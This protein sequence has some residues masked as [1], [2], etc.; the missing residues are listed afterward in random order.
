MQDLGYHQDDKICALATGWGQSALGVI[1]VSGEASLSAL[2]TVFSR[3]RALR[4]ASGNSLVYGYIL[5]A[6]GG[7]PVDQVLVAVFRGGRSYTGQE[8]AE[9]TCHGGIPAVQG[10]LE[11]LRGAGFRDAAPGEFTLRAFVSGKI[12]LT[13]AEAVHEIVT[14]KTSRAHDLALHRLSGSVEARVN[15]VKTRLVKMMSALELQ[16]DYPEDEVGD[17]ILPAPE[18]AGAE[19]RELED[20]S[21]T[22]R[23]GRLYQEGIKIALTGRTNAG[24]SSLF[25]LFLREDRAIVSEV[26]GTTRDYLESWISLAGIPVCLIDTAGFRDADNSVE[27]EGIRR[28]QEISR[29]SHLVLYLVD[30]A[31][32]MNGE[33]RKVWENREQ[34]GVLVVWNKVDRAEAQDFPEGVFPVSALDGGGFDALQQEILRRIHGDELRMA[35]DS[36]QAVIDS[37]RQKRLLDR[38]VEALGHVE[39]GLRDGAPLDGVAMDL[40]EVLDS[41]GEITGEVTSAQILDT[42]FSGFCV[43]K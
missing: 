11:S 4:E 35:V 27:A 20:L 40:R 7:D 34:S 22:Y 5:K 3:P 8:S 19:R 26:H 13:R 36:G 15:T 29:E 14:A 6:P 43:G 38:A 21:A 25:N 10:I 17:E 1:R 30:G 28:S 31:E 16:L 2:E 42:M 23:A 37:A 41:L 32:G 9:I 39:S 12:D 18:D 33:D 24:K